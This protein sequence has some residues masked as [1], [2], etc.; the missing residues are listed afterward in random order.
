MTGLSQYTDKVCVNED[1][2]WSLII[3]PVPSIPFISINSINTLR[4]RQNCRHFAVDIFKISL[5]FVSMI[6]IYNI[7]ALLQIMA[8]R[9]LGDKP[10]SEPIMVSLLTLIY[11]T[12]PQWVNL[13]NVVYLSTFVLINICTYQHYSVFCGYT[14]I[15]CNVGWGKSQIELKFWLNSLQI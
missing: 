7:P 6:R 11:V 14:S 12:R 3:I 1:R 8:W 15:L 5:K 9:R 2:R 4:P 10:L 13:C